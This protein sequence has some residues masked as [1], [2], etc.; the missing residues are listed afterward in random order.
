MAGVALGNTRQI[1]RRPFRAPFLFGGTMEDTAFLLPGERLD[2]V[3]DKIRLI[4]KPDGLTFGTDALL[5]AGFVRGEKDSAVLELGGGSGI[6]SLLLLGRDKCRTCHVAEIQEDYVDL[7]RR[8]ATLN[9]ME[10]RFF[11]LR[12]DVRDLSTLPGA[13]RFDRVVS[14]PPYMAVGHGPE[15]GHTPKNIARREV[16]GDI[17]AF[18]RAAAYSLRWGGTFSVVYRAGRAVDLL[19]AMRESG[20]EPKRLTPVMAETDRDPVLLLAEGKKGGHPDLTFTRPLYLY[21]SGTREYSPE[22][23]TILETGSFPF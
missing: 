9:G 15:N 7:C 22:M 17:R 10:E 2:E 18:C 19:C 8:N 23:E 4:Q 6:I 20:I 14:N 3:N 1:S 21:K 11:P 5:L 12:A 16:M 13:E